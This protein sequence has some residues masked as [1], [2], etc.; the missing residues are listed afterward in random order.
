MNSPTNT[1][2]QVKSKERV[3]KHGEVF[4]PQWVVNDML[5]LLP[6][7]V[8]EPDKTFLE[9]ACGE[10]AFLVEIYRRKLQNI[11]AETQNEWE[12]QA[13]IATG[14]IYGIELLEDNAKQCIENL[15]QIFTDFYQRLYP[16]TQDNELIKTVQFLIHRNIIQGNALTCR[17]C[18]LACGNE[19]SKCEKIVFS[20]WKAVSMKKEQSTMNNYLFQRR[21]YTYEG[22]IDADK[23]QKS[24]SGG[25]FEAVF[26]K[27]EHGLIKEYKP[28][29]YKE[30]Q[31]VKG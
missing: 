6:A 30:I 13:A 8:W 2:Q 24:A 10:G 7:D 18:S 22:I 5:D 26:S 17:K 11:K 29:N 14:S 21:D 16:D 27:E 23:M 19:C 31:Y 28:V 3:Q 25:I 20:E 12:W 4:T 9:P 15:M 1:D